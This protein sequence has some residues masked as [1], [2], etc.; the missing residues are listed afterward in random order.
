MIL[1]F[2]KKNS[3][4]VYIIIAIL[5]LS[6]MKNIQKIIITTNVVEYNYIHQDIVRIIYTFILCNTVLK[7][8]HVVCP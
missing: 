3:K 1:V 7:K 5:L 2:I 4:V 6:F 8:S